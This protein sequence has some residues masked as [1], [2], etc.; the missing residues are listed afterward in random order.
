MLRRIRAHHPSHATVVAYLALFVAMGGT[1]YAAATIGSAQVVDNSLESR[2]LKD[3]AGV[4]TQDIVNDTVT[5]GGLA[6]VDVRANSLTSADV[7]A[8]TGA[9][10][11]DGSLKGDDIDESSL[12]SV[13]NAAS[14]DSASSV[15]L[16][17]I[18]SASVSNNSLASEDIVTGALLAEDIGDGQVTR[19]KLAAGA[20]DACPSP[21]TARFGRICAGSPDSP[22]TFVNATSHCASYGLRL[23]SPSEAAT[24]A[25]NYDVP[26]VGNPP[27]YFWTDDR[28]VVPSN[29]GIGV[30]LETENGTGQGLN[31]DALTSRETV[32]VTMPSTL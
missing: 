1:A 27:E 19:A 6:S 22:K 16:N 18:N 30:F 24:L 23:P 13:P 25:V 31:A 11:T 26:G 21:L 5:G 12:G 3:G 15:A 9:D 7:A 2:D 8:L 4:R 17:S 32:C 14:A 28:F 20:A 29:D 10:V